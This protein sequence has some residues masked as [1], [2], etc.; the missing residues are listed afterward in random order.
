MIDLND[1][2]D[3]M[4]FSVT[5]PSGKLICQYMEV[6]AT[7][8]GMTDKEPTIEHVVRAIRESSRT[9]EVAKATPDAMLVAAWQ[10]MSKAVDAQGNG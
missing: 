4:L 3:P 2:N 8:Q 5:L 7:V 9:P 10:R 1:D 6:L